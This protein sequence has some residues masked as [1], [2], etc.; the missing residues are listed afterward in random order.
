[1]LSDRER[2]AAEWP[3]PTLTGT[4]YLMKPIAIVQARTTSTRLPGK[5]LMD[6]C[7]QT[8]LH[9][10][11]RRCQLSRRLAGVVLATTDEPADDCL[12][13][14]AQSLGI[15]AFRGSRDDVLDRFVHAAQGAG[16]DPIVRITSD[17]PLIEP[18][19][20]DSVV[21]SYERTVADLVYTDGF[22]RGT[23]DS[24]L[25]PMAALRKAWNETRPDEAYYREH[26]LTYHWRHPERFRHHVVHAPP[27]I[28]RVDYRLCVDEADDLEV[29]RRICGHFAP[30][31][32]FSL[33]EVVA[34]LE[35]NP[36]ISAINR[37]VVQKPA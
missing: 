1:L 14:M 15:A 9:Y 12:V 2:G 35:R 22:P 6:L 31:V 8:V 37:H 7:G 29:I 20:I 36:E 3:G 32:D 21:E 17:C 11:V 24:E 19:V 18:A 30:R 27:E 26:V 33:A 28:R 16:A 25:V 13:E 5:V 4:A 34:F 23:G 10:V